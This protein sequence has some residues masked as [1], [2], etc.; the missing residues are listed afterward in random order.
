MGIA[1]ACAGKVRFNPKVTVGGFFVDILSPLSQMEV[2][3]NFDI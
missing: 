2:D 3:Y 1:D